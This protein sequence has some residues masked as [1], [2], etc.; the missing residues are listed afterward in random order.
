[1]GRVVVVGERKVD[2]EV[3]EREGKETF[4]SPS[5]LAIDEYRQGSSTID[6]ASFSL[7]LWWL[8]WEARTEC[9]VSSVCARTCTISL[10][11]GVFLCVII[12]PRSHFRNLDNSPLYWGS[13][14]Q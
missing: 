9:F 4:C 14:K 11:M 8:L 1:M 6:R 2:G 7:G 13:V 3:C 5:R 12:V 10:N